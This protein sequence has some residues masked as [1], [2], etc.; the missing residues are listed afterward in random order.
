MRSNSRKGPDQGA[1]VG[2]VVY[3]AVYHSSGDVRTVLAATWVACVINTSYLIL[4][5][6]S[7][8][9]ALLWAAG[10]RWTFVGFALLAY[11]GLV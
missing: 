5:T 7:R 10:P 1:L 4:R 9:R 3:G 11:K 8:I 6:R 2:V